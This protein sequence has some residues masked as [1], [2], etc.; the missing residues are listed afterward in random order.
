[1]TGLSTRGRLTKTR[2]C[3]AAGRNAANVT[4]TGYFPA[5]F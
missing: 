1:M 3:V 4:T 2:V 5:L